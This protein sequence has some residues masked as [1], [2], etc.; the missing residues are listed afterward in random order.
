MV[1]CTFDGRRRNRYLKMGCVWCFLF[2]FRAEETQKLVSGV[3]YP[4]IVGIRKS[5]RRQLTRK[6]NFRKRFSTIALG[7]DEKN[8]AVVVMSSSHGT[9]SNLP[10]LGAA[11][12]AST[13]FRSIYHRRWPSRVGPRSGISVAVADGSDLPFFIT[14]RIIRESC[15]IFFRFFFHYFLS[16]S[17]LRFA[18]RTKHS[19]PRF[20]VTLWPKTFC[21]T[22][23]RRRQTTYRSTTA[24][25]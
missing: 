8:V 1:A 17:R 3:R 11:T 5:R 16:L 9:R 7:K 6:Q 15:A 14:R 22:R 24:R 20:T 21:E 19:F 12:A 4:V 25:F 2:Y 18:R 10:D 13:G 23:R